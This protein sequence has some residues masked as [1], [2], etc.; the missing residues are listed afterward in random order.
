MIKVGTKVQYKNGKRPDGRTDLY[1]YVV[2]EI[3]DGKAFIVKEW[4][5]LIVC[6]VALED[7]TTDIEEEW[8]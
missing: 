6:W 5:L 3:K 7:L 2:K 1:T 8:C 4:G